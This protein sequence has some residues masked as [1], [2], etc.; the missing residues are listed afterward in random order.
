M[1]QTGMTTP[2]PAA[3]AAQQ[4]QQQQNPAAQ[5]GN[6]ADNPLKSTDMK[7]N[8][9]GGAGGGGGP[10]GGPGGGG[11]GNNAVQQHTNGVAG[12]ANGGDQ[13]QQNNT[14]RSNYYKTFVPSMIRTARPTVQLVAMTIL[15]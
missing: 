10:G 4:Q 12:M 13:L 14:V 7:V 5:N 2:Y 3:F 8:D 1:V 9:V 6:P 15:T 11:G